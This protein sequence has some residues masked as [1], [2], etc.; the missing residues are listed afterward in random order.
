MVRKFY[1]GLENTIR[2]TSK[3][4]FGKPWGMYLPNPSDF[5][6]LIVF[7]YYGTH[8]H[9]IN[10]REVCV[11]KADRELAKSHYRMGYL[12]WNNAADVYEVA[13]W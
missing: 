2:H 4:D 8:H 10:T 12:N 9:N 7:T 5:G 6:R 13:R 3:F 1:D 11:F